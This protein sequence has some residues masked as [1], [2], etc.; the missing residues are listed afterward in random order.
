VAGAPNQTF[1]D[2]EVVGVAGGIRNNWSQ[3]DRK[4]LLWFPLPAKGVSGSIF[5]RLQ[6]DSTAVMRGVEHLA[7]AAGVPVEFKEKMVTIVE[8]SLWPFRAFAR[9]SGALSGLALIMA[10]VGLYGVMSFGVNQRV[11]EIGVRMALGAT[12]A[13][14]TA[15]FVRQGMRLVAWGVALGLAGG[16]G[17]A[18]LLG[19]ALPGA[20]FAGDLAFRGL[21]FAVVTGFLVSVALV[22][23]WLPARRAAKVDPMVALRAE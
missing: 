12:A 7:A 16:T 23:C 20:G 14:V 17:F 15:L 11:K 10:T 4:E 22:A 13:R 1:R 5:V 6:T 21:V 19:K 3:N 18:V 9:F 2:Y 8:R